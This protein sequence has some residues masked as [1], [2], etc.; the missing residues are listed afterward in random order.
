MTNIEIGNMTLGAAACCHTKDGLNGDP[1]GQV[2]SHVVEIKWVDP[3]GQFRQVDTGNT[4]L[5][6]MVGSSYGLCG[7]FT[8]QLLP[9][10]RRR[11]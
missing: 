11:S 1:L 8:K 2:S 9:S 3:N 6:S 5:L 7:S 10:S 4:S